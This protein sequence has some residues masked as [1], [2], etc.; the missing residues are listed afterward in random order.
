MIVDMFLN[1]LH[2]I[3]INSLNNELYQIMIKLAKIN[4]HELSL[5][6]LKLFPWLNESVLAE[7]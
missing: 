1:F 3:K 4:T 2:F 7:V 6:I 5:I